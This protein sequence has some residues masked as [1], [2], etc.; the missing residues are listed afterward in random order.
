MR[1]CPKGYF[2]CSNRKC[3]PD[4][5]QCNNINE[6]G[7]NSDERKCGC[8]DNEFRCGDGSCILER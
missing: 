6:C 5:K 1:V 3:I 2:H 8:R 4:S 7:D